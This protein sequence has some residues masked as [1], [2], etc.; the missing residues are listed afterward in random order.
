MGPTGVGKTDLAMD[1]YEQIPIEIISVDS[2]QIYK[3]LD[4]GSGKPSKEVL[5]TFPHEMIDIIECSENYSTAKFQNDCLACIKKA[6]DGNKIPVLVGGSMMYFHHLVNGLSKLPSVSQETRYKVQ[7][8]FEEKGSIE[9]HQYLQEIDTE[10]SLKI[11]KNDSQRIKRAIEVFK[12]TGKQ[13]S[14]LQAQQKKEIDKLI[15]S[16]NL[17]QIAIKPT[18]KAM[19]REV[20][21][22]RFKDMIEKGL[23]EE[24]EK[25]LDHKNISRNSQSM[26]SVGYRQVCDFLEGDIDLDDMIEKGINATRQL[27]KRQMTWI[28]SWKDLIILEKNAELSTSVKRIIDQN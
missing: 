20:V 2:V 22:N 27:A 15:S 16:S 1:L 10:A 6:F 19:H 18:D 4:I 17:K 25:I 13:F 8:E 24:V 21:A 9:M 14:Q 28:N 12:E 26:K 11:H 7:K 5:K 3:N 23:I